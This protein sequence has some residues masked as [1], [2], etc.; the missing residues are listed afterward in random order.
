VGGTSGGEE[1]R[2][3]AAWPGRWVRAVAGGK[4]GF[5]PWSRGSLHPQ[6]KGSKGESRG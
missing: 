4:N 2:V 6:E 5:Q 1:A 3:A